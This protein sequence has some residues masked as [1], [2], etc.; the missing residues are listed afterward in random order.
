MVRNGFR[1]STVVPVLRL[2]QRDSTRTSTINLF[3]L[4]GCT[5]FCGI[6]KRFHGVG[7]SAR[8][9]PPAPKSTRSRRK[10]SPTQPCMQ[11]SSERQ[12]ELAVLFESVHHLTDTLLY[13]TVCPGF[14]RAFFC[15]YLGLP[16]FPTHFIR[17]ETNAF[18]GAGYE[19]QAFW[20]CKRGM[21]KHPGLRGG[22]QTS[23]EELRH[24]RLQP[25]C[26]WAI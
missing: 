11:G 1:P 4:Q 12:V 7:T 9:I 3:F 25:Q 24:P 18:R 15:W 17:G 2:A 26:P 5:L 20:V 6:S 8:T 23:T 10:I 22:R 14:L 13:P 19:H 16:W 21:Y